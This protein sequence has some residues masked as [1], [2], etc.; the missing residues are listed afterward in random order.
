MP[1]TQ[2]PINHTQ[3]LNA[4]E[5]LDLNAARISKP[6]EV[7]KSKPLPKDTKPKKISKTIKPQK[8]IKQI[9][10]Q[11]SP[12]IMDSTHSV[13]DEPSQSMQGKQTN[14]PVLTQA[15]AP[16]LAHKTVTPRV[17]LSEKISYDIK[18]LL[19]KKAADIDI[20]DLLVAVPALKRELIKAIR[21]KTSNSS[22]SKLPL[23]FF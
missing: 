17:P 4:L 15:F 12:M 20:G 14:L 16:K 19:H 22:N 6:L 21:E 23:T 10:I 13:M 3:S 2:K 11:D 9:T 5:T 7:A 18:E 8:N 1:T